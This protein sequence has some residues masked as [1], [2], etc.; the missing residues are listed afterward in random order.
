MSQ[1]VSSSHFPYLPIHVKIGLDSESILF[2]LDQE[3]LVDTGFDGGLSIPKSLIIKPIVPAGHQLWKL[4][5]ETEIVTFVYLG[6]VKIGS[7]P[8]VATTIIALGDELLLGRNVTNHFRL[9][10]DHGN[11]LIVE[12]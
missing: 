2:E 8:A 10:F 12:Q 5:D 9:I 6:H 3:A 11:Q 7:L 4:A 1:S